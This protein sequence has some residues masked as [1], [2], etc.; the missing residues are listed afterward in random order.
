MMQ[1]W[2]IFPHAHVN[3]YYDESGRSQRI[4]ALL[5]AHPPDSVPKFTL[6]GMEINGRSDSAVVEFC[7]AR[8]PEATNS[9]TG[10][11][12]PF[13]GLK[14]NYWEYT[15]HCYYSMSVLPKRIDDQRDGRQPV[16]STQMGGQMGDWDF[17]LVDY[18]NQTTGAI[19][20]SAL[21][22]CKV[23]GLERVAVAA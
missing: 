5:L 23:G 6:F 19:N 13:A 12:A 10:L 22:L 18:W 9:Y 15:D 8:W 3:V 16:P 20:R 4:E 7:R 17:P 1:R 14:A 11:E 21:R 2:T